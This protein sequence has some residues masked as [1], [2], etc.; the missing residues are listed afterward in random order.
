MVIYHSNNPP[1][2]N[3]Q[4]NKQK[5]VVCFNSMVTCSCPST[6]CFLD[7]ASHHCEMI[8][9]DSGNRNKPRVSMPQIQ[10]V[11]WLTFLLHIPWA[12]KKNG[13]TF[14]EVCLKGI[15]ILVNYNPHMDVSKNKGTPKF[16]ILIGFSFINHPFWSTPIFGNTHMAA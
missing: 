8:R 1:T 5:L 6:P 15:L 10:R 7:P 3:H 13:L 4:L 12:T 14:H 11:F 16:S 2:K 9:S